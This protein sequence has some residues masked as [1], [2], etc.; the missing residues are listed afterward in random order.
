M[1]RGAR[2]F[3]R[4]PSLLVFRTAVAYISIGQRSISMEEI[5]LLSHRS[6]RASR[7]V[8]RINRQIVDVI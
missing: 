2:M 8:M 4:H 6:T 7:R 1:M 5:G 3:V